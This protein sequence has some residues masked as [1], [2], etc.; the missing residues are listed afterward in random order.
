[1]V[2]GCGA[3]GSAICRKLDEEPAVEEII[4]ADYSLE[5]AQAVCGLMKKG[6]PVRVDASV[7][8]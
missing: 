1:M 7:R 2:C 4:C 8:S 3:Q 5:A 6:K